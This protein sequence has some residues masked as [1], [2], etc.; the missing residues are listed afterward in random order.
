MLHGPTKILTHNY[1]HLSN[2]QGNIIQFRMKV[3]QKKATPSYCHLYMQNLGSKTG[4]NTRWT[5]GAE[6]VRIMFK[7]ETNQIHHRL[8]FLAP[9]HQ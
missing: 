1:I 4:K 6:I 3:K 8:M 9:T 5:D 2:I 7:N